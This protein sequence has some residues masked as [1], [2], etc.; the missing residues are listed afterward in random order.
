MKAYRLFVP[1]ALA[2]LAL[3]QLSKWWARSAL[4]PG[5]DAQV[6]DGVWIHR[7]SFNPGM[8][9]SMLQHFG[10]ARVVLSIVALLACVAIV[11]MLRRVD[12]SRRVTI[13]GYAL[14]AAGALGNAIDRIY[15]GVVTDFIVWRAGSH[16]WP[17]FNVADAL[18]LAGVGLLAIF[19]SDR[20]GSATAL[21]A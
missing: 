16:E 15:S 11:V 2:A 6:L 13:I 7:L 20:R 1:V 18:L 10:G 19:G 4:T 21:R 5:R 8:S 9:F 3:D 14:I 12:P 17:V